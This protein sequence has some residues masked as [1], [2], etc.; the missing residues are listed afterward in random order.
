[1]RAPE[2][3]LRSAPKRREAHRPTT[4]RQG[5]QRRAKPRFY[6]RDVAE[7]FDSGFEA[8]YDVARAGNEQR[9]RL[10]EEYLRGRPLDSL[11][12]LEL[13]TLGS[14]FVELARVATDKAIEARRAPRLQL[15]ADDGELTEA[16]RR[17]IDDL[18]RQDDG[19]I[20][21]PLDDEDGDR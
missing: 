2:R 10:V 4:Y 1:V 18:T 15:I 21:L 13:Q 12:A 14:E 20:D 7:S 8:G 6:A 16:G 17:L 5:V 11:S 19:D 3:T 9:N